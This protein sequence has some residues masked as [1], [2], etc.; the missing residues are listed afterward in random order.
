[1][2]YPEISLA[3]FD[4]ISVEKLSADVSDAD[5]DQM[6]DTLRKQR[7]TWAEKDG[8]A[9]DGDRV[10]IDYEGFKDGEAFAGGSAKGQN[11]VLGSGSMIPGFEDRSE[12]HTSELQSR[13]NLVC[14]LLLGKKKAR[15]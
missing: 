15:M 12:E 1:D 14:R 5:I 7:A 11:L 3:A 4:S 10:N 6:I 2:V 8:A 13:E 9:A